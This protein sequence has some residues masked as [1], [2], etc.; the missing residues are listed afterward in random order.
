MGLQTYFR[1]VFRV[2]P[3]RQNSLAMSSGPQNPSERD[4]G[5]S[6]PDPQKSLVRVGR[7]K[8]LNTVQKSGAAQFLHPRRR[9][10]HPKG[11]VQ[12]QGEIIILQMG[13]FKNQY[14]ISNAYFKISN[15]IRILIKI[16]SQSGSLNSFLTLTKTIKIKKSPNYLKNT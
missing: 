7:P 1:S 14:V 16:F 13:T 4:F 12:T 15:I 9:V 3:T 10:R 8:I 11:R 5:Q 6:Q 2:S